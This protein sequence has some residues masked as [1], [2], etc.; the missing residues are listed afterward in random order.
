ML[1]IFVPPAFEL[2]IVGP[3]VI[4]VTL[5]LIPDKLTCV[6]VT[7]LKGQDTDTVFVVSGP[8]ANI[9]T[10]RCPLK[11]AKA[12]HF[13]RQPMPNVNA[14]LVGISERVKPEHRLARS[15]FERGI[16]P[17]YVEP[18]GLFLQARPGSRRLLLAD[19][20]PLH[21]TMPVHH[22]VL[23]AAFIAL[24]LMDPFALAISETVDELARK[25]TIRVDPFLGPAA[26]LHVVSP[27]A[28]VD[29]PHSVCV[30][31]LPV[32][33]GHLEVAHVLVPQAVDEDAVAARVTQVPITDITCAVGPV[34]A[35][36]AIPEAA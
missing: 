31:P 20:A 12:V 2:T 25:H 29:G 36:L 10:P 18:G 33:H 3:L 28:L 21:H 15:S 16:V 4:P 1:F 23:P 9:Q 32:R 7:A 13:I 5:S 27:F 35:P 14:L 26:M 24:V 17:S 6:L 30:R 19:E 34:H 11:D 22:V 8:L